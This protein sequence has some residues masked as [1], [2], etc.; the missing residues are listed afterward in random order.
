MYLRGASK[1]KKM[2]LLT[3]MR[4][5]TRKAKKM[6][7]DLMAKDSPTHLFMCDTNGQFIG[8]S[9][10]SVGR[11]LLW[12]YVALQ[13][14]FPCIWCK[15][16]KNCIDKQL[17]LTAGGQAPLIKETSG[18]TCEWLQLRRL[19]IQ[20]LNSSLTWKLIFWPTRISI[21]APT[22]SSCSGSQIKL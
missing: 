15:N 3:A 1:S 13:L 8:L 18:T 5:G 19:V 4:E 6:K 12:K 21:K 9:R 16:S 14:D 2:D 10:L 20:P 7:E 17:S 11:E 22:V